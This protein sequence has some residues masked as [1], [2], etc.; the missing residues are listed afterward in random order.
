MQLHP[1]WSIDCHSTPS[2]VV[3]P[4]DWVHQVRCL[5]FVVVQVQP[6]EIVE[7]CWIK[8]LESSE[9]N[10][11]NIKYKPVSLFRPLKI[12]ESTEVNWS[13][14]KYNLSRL[15]I[16]LNVFDSNLV[17]WL[18]CMRRYL[19]LIGLLKV[20][21]FSSVNWLPLKLT[22]W[23]ATSPLKVSGCIEDSLLSYK[24]NSCS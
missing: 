15:A 2:R 19:K 13:L 17:S 18:F 6:F 16:L 4:G 11:L 20:A 7:C 5:Q 12:A 14:S 24:C 3:C 21:G 9:A 8:I 1:S 10:W 23:R 22:F